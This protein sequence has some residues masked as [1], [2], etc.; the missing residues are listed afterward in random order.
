MKMIH[1]FVYT[2]C[3]TSRV[4]IVAKIFYG[5]ADKQYESVI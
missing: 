3:S 4:F 1:N 5:T 2:A